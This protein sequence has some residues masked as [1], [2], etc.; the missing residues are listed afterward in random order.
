MFGKSF[1]NF[2]VERA[3]IHLKCLHNR[4]SDLFILY[5]PF[6]DESS[7]SDD[8]NS[9]EKFFRSYNSEPK[10]KL[11]FASGFAHTICAYFFDGQSRHLDEFHKTGC[12]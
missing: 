11:A 2:A 7:I 3:S 8:K 12:R 4:S 6:G 5:P 9:N 1:S 10:I